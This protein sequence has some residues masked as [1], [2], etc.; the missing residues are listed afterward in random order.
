MITVTDYYFPLGIPGG[1]FNGKFV[2]TFHDYLRDY[3]IHFMRYLYFL[4]IKNADGD[5]PIEISIEEIEKPSKQ[6]RNRPLLIKKF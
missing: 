6:Y 2:P 5:Y 4:C 3:H 1:Y